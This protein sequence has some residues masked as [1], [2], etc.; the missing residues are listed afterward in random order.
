M[1]PR[2]LHVKPFH[3]R[4]SCEAHGRRACDD[5]HVL[6]VLSPAKR[7]DVESK[8]TTRKRTEPRLLEHTAELIEVMRTKSADEVAGLMDLSPELAELNVKRYAD[9]EAVPSPPG[10]RPAILT[11]AGDVAQGMDPWSFTERDLTEA[12]KT[13]RVLSGLYGLLRPLDLV[14]P[15]RLE[16][17]TRLETDRGRSL[18]DFWGTT[19]TDLLAEDL[20]ASPGP[21]VLVDLASEEYFKAVRPDRL[22]APVVAPRFLDQAP[23]GDWRVIS[24]LAKWARGAMA[25]WIV[26]NRIRSS[27]ALQD[28]DVA[29]YR[30]DKSR[31]T[32][33]QP[34]FTRTKADR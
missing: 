29:G 19:I 30:Y 20:E 17:G 11:F 5:A 10:A 22:D 3:A 12:Q 26:R 18:Y 4:C 24:F 13:V 34:T 27:R 16:M 2:V 7:L 21:G 14:Q 6:I 23:N 28:F 1:R 8:L 15:Y 9:L 33:A 32:A 31:S 25:G